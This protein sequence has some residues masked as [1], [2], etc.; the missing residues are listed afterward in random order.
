MRPVTCSLALSALCLACADT[1]TSTRQASLPAFDAANAP[2]TSGPNVVRL[3]FIVGVLSGDADLAVAVGFEDPF[4]DHCADFVS[5]GQPGSTQLVFTRPG[6]LHVKESGRDVN[7]VV[8]EFA[9]VLA[10]LCQDL[11]EAPVVATGTANVTVTSN[12][13]FLGGDGRGADQLQAT[14]YG[15]VDL[16]SG[17]QA[18]LFA[19]TH[20]LVRPDGSFAFDHTR[21]ILTPL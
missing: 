1:P 9:G 21:I 4:K 15:V 3:P 20:V 13:L 16:A 14:I 19:T 5:P 6:D 2:P 11:V 18:R 7:V 17:G 12:N 10:D 8:Y